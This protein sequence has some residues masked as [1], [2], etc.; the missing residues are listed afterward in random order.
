MIRKSIVLLLAVL[1]LQ[2]LSAEKMF[3]QKANA[4]Y[5][6]EVRLKHPAQDIFDARQL[7]SDKKRIDPSNNKLI[8]I[9][10]DF[11]EEVIDDAST[12]GN[13]K[14]ETVPNPDYP[15]TIG[16]PPHDMEYYTQMMESLRYYYAA[17][18]YGLFDLDYDIWPKDRPAYTL[19]NPMSY[20]SPPN[21]GSD[22]FVERLEEFFKEAWETADAIDPEIDFSQYGH[23]M[24]LHA[25]SDWQHDTLGDTPS[26]MPSL[27]IKIATG[28]EAVVDNGAV[29]ITHSCNVP[30]TISQDPREYPYTDEFGNE[31]GTTVY[32][33]GAT[34]AVFAHEFGHSMGLVD[35]YNTYTSY[36]MVGYFDIMD[37]GG[38]G[39][40]QSEGT[41]DGK[42]YNIEGGLPA[43]PGAFSRLLMFED[44][45]REQGILKDV[46]ELQ[47]ETPFELSA[48]ETRVKPTDKLRIIKIPLSDMEYVLLEHRSVDP[49]GDGDTAVKSALNQ[50]VILYPTP[51]ADNF[52]TPSYEY[53][54][55]LPSWQKWNSTAGWYYSY[56]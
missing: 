27:F 36:P 12:T 21:V 18:S 16:S 17:A 11:Q 29:L 35:L 26:D 40:L 1:I 56:G 48:A 3:I 30:E 4:P 9:M 37:S 15:I 33:Y 20:Y 24:I 45:F 52:D 22:L 39:I 42:L 6:R 14:F 19:S 49:D 54:Y 23:F 2:T 53:D 5:D 31:I 43:L 46:T 13:G 38:A 41:S 44:T 8:V 34:N 10:V 7:K 50:R 28:K 55:L 47:L 32:G 25:G 51:R